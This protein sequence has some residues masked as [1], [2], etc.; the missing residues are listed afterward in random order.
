VSECRAIDS[1]WA[2][3]GANLAA[4]RRRRRRS[5]LELAAAVGL[6]QQAISLIESGR[7][8]ISLDTR[9]ALARELRRNPDRLFP[10]SV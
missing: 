6:S 5:Q 1:R 10:H 2:V 8:G 4:A 7:R 3:W 9:M